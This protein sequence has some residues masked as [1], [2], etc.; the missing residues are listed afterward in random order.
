MFFESTC[1]NIGKIKLNNVDHLGYASLGS[2]YIVNRNVNAKKTQGFGQ[3]LADSTLR[4]DL[5][6]MVLDE[7]FNDRMAVK[8]NRKRDVEGC[9]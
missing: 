6:H 3:Q 8:M 7:D 5:V 1:I 4:I 2:N 9:G